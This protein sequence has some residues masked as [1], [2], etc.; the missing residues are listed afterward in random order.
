L[1]IASLFAPIN[2]I[3]SW[4]I[5]IPASILLVT[6]ILVR[7]RSQPATPPKPGPTDGL[8]LL[9]L[10][11]LVL[12]LMHFPE[13]LAQALQAFVLGIRPAHGLLGTFDLEWVHAIYNTIFFVGLVLIFFVGE[14]HRKDG[15]VWNKPAVGYLFMGL[16]VFQGYHVVEHSVR[17]V[18][19]FQ[20]GL[21]GTPGI[22]GQFI[23]LIVL[24]FYYTGG[25]LVV[26]S[27]VIVGYGFDARI[28]HLLLHRGTPA[29]LAVPKLSKVP[30][31][32]RPTPP[33]S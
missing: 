12:Q 14:F 24:H 7:F 21:Q 28:G 6:Y 13:H 25:A 11:F 2:N 3:Y 15:W 27:M 20:T 30:T 5:I 4:A 9:I 32:G 31:G 1:D 8:I 22:L 16:T 26:F 23:N 33:T 18:Q 29:S 17:M 19:H 10:I